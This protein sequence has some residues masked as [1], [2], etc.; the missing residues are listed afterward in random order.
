MSG[1]VNGIYTGANQGIFDGN[2]TGIEN[3]VGLGLQVERI[4]QN[5]I[6]RNGLVLYLDA[7]N[8]YSYSGSGTGI[9]WRDISGNGNNGTLTNGPT[10][11]SGNGGSIFFDGLNDV[12]TLNTP[13]NAPSAISYSQGFWFK[14]ITVNSFSGFVG[15]GQNSINNNRFLI[16]VWNDSLVYL[17]IN[18]AWGT[19]VSNDTNWHHIFMCFNGLQSNTASRLIGY[20]DGSQVPLTFTGTIPNSL[21]NV[22]YTGYRV[23]RTFTNSNQ[24]GASNISVVQV[25]NRALTAQEVL[26]NYNATK[27]RFG[28]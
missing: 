17:T 2:N 6:V 18:N 21:S 11:N 1:V 7:S 9:T 15:F 8:T 28:L 4:V 14:R 12:V 26:Q 10:F 19:F 24:Y 3:G 22:V 20:L 23:G 27:T 16:Q 25:Y 5:P 13:N